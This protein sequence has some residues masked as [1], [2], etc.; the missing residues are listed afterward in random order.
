MVTRRQ[1]VGLV[2]LLT[3]GAILAE[4][5]VA[6]GARP[7]LHKPI[8]EKPLICPYCGTGCGMIAA[9]QEGKLVNL[10]GDPDH[11]I[12]QGALCSKGQAAR[13]FVQSPHRVTKVLY[14][15]P[16]SDRWEEKDWAWA[17]DRIARLIK[18]TRDAE[19]VETDDL[20]QVV[21]RTESI[22]TLGTSVVS[23]EGAY[24]MSKLFRALGIVYIEHQA[25]LCHS[26]TV[27]ALGVSFGRGAMTNHSI[28]FRNADVILV[29]GGNPAEQHPLTFRWILEAKERGAKLIVVDPRFNRTAS[30]ADIYAQIRPGTDIAFMGGLIRYILENKRYDEFYVKHY[31]NAPFLVNPDF[32]TATELD[33]LFSGYD[34]EKRQYDTGSWSYQVDENGMVKKD[35]SLTDPHTVFQLLRKQYERY[36]PEL[37]SKITGIPVEKL[38]AIYGLYSSTGRPDRAGT[39]TYAMGATQ[40]TYGTQHIRTYAIVQLLLGNIGIPGGGINALRGHSNVQGS[41]DFALLYQDLPG[42]LGIPTGDKPTLKDWLESRV[43]KANNAPSA[44]WWQN[45]PKYFVSLL[46]AWWPKVDP[47]TAYAFLPKLSPHKGGVPDKSA[48]Y[49]HYAIF[50]AILEG[51]IKGLI[52]IG[53]NPAS[54]A[55]NVNLVWK[56]LD[57]LKWLVVVDP[58]ETETAA[59]WKRPGVDPK[60]IQT[61][62]FLLPSAVWA[63]KSGSIT[64][65]GRWAQ[66]YDKVLDPPGEAKD[67]LWILTELVQRLKK[68]YAEEGGPNKEAILELSWWER[69]EKMSEEVAKEYNGYDLT[70]GKLMARFADLRDDGTTACGNWLYCGAFTEEGNKMARRDPRD[71]HPLGLGLF[72]NWAYSWPANR[73]ILYN[74]ASTDLTGQPRNPDKWLV[75]WNPKEEKWEG[76]VPDGT[77]PP[78]KALPFIMLPEGVGRLFAAQL[79]D[80]PFPEHYEPWESALANLISGQDKNPVCKVWVSDLDVYGSPEEYPIVATTYRLTEH[81][82]TGMMSRN[83]PWLLELQPDPFVEMDVELAKSLGIKNGDWVRIKSARGEMRAVALVTPRILP[84]KVGDKT[85]H[86]VGIAIHWGYQGGNPGENV[87]QLTPQALDPNT[88]IQE[89]KAFLVRIERA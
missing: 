76:D 43:P 36:T 18:D 80:G 25:R 85:L 40:H 89:T 78:E 15:A 23:N 5:G 54:S 88:F 35:M 20:G 34:P 57:N 79:R 16:G 6:Q 45:Y 52:A 49:S 62:A 28:D 17:L 4:R 66:W 33:G 12:N 69:S 81:W 61:E 46:K 56:A 82:H 27:P 53:Q 30:K 37:V 72:H 11:P 59:H 32:K 65:T 14:R 22:A 26:S 3:G 64:N 73:R 71:T 83:V 77:A 74:R 39:I 10:E 68:M 41:T 70:T 21:S 8:G 47:E 67:E 9:V 48:D 63:E 60:A 44:N 75:R 38:L 29:Q 86:Q 1:F 87:N 42:Y 7:V 51:R 19:W 13:G 24:A 84:V 31:T 50:H 2:G 58:M 55:A